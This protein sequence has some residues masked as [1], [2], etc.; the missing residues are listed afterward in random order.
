MYWIWLH[1]FFFP[2][3]C[4]VYVTMDSYL[5]AKV[6]RETVAH[7]L[8]QAVA[9]RMDVPAS[10]LIL[11]AITYPGGKH[12]YNWPF[13][14][15]IHSW[16]M[17]SP[18]ISY[19]VHMWCIMSNDNCIPSLKCCKPISIFNDWSNWLPSSRGCKGVLSLSADGCLQLPGLILNGFLPFVMFSSLQVDSSSSL[20]TEFSP[21]L[22][23]Q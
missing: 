12:H 8:L 17:L 18:F 13:P 16:L 15:H 9:E 20:R 6:H 11:V 19:S 23:G 1:I 21:V 7:E 14:V 2:V 4:R 5:S 3:L 10:E 22:Y